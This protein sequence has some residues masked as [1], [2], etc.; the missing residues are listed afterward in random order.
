MS[1]LGLQNKTADSMKTEFNSHLARATTAQEETLIHNYYERALKQETDDLNDKFKQLRLMKNHLNETVDAHHLENNDI[2]TGL[3]GVD[4]VGRTV[5]SRAVP[6]TFKGGKFQC[7]L[8]FDYD[9]DTSTRK[10]IPAGSKIII[11]D[12]LSPFYGV[13]DY[14]F[15]ESNNVSTSDNF[16]IKINFER[17]SQ[18]EELRDRVADGSLVGEKILISTI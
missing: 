3:I 11:R 9:P 5:N 15:D 13:A 14:V 12:A 10:P 4:Y 7:M 2:F 8:Y 17:Q 16:K 6:V 1:L 18:A